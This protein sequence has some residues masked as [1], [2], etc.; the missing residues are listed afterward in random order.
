MLLRLI[1]HERPTGGIVNK[2][3]KTTWMAE[4]GTHIKS[5]KYFDPLQ[6]L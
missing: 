6:H 1:T 5:L 4:T 3:K 2:E